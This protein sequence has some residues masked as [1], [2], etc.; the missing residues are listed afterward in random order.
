[1]TPQPNAPP[2]QPSW[3]SQNWKWLAGGGCLLAL[4]CCGLFAVVGGW[5]SLQQSAPGEDLPMNRA[6]GDAARVDCGTPG[7]EGVDCDVKRTAGVGTIKACWTLAITCANQ[8]VM[9][10]EACGTVAAGEDRTTVTMPVAAFSNHD[11]CDAPKVGTV[12]GLTVQ[13]VE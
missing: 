11:G 8:G 6:T 10:G 9:E 12:K 1:M 3:F 5:L 7:P 2:S 4:M 13:T